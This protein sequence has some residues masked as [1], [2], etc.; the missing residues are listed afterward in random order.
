MA[1]SLLQALW[2]TAEVAQD[3]G[4]YWRHYPGVHAPDQ[5]WTSNR[6]AIR[7]VFCDMPQDEFDTLYNACFNDRPQYH[8][9]RT[10]N[11]GEYV[12]RC[13][14][15]RITVAEQHVDKVLLDEYNESVAALQAVSPTK[16][17]TRL[18]LTDVMRMAKEQS[19]PTPRKSLSFP[20]TPEGQAAAARVRAK[21]APVGAPPA[22]KSSAA[23]NPGA[24]GS[25]FVAGMAQQLAS[26]QAQLNAITHPAPQGQRPLP[27]QTDPSSP[28]CSRN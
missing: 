19:S 16:S 8:V 27:P 14:G 6:Q 5:P 18:N 15:G 4:F 25:A 10:S 12:V 20:P 1:I 23:D 9:E 17:R 21:A 2:N 7:E 11:A 28:L 13:L 22:A 26:L 3:P 24:Q